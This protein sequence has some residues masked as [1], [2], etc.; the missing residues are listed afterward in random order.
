MPGKRLLITWLRLDPLSLLRVSNWIYAFLT[1]ELFWQ[2]SDDGVVLNVMPKTF[3][4]ANTC[5]SGA[6]W[7]AFQYQ[8]PKRILENFRN[9]VVNTSRYIVTLFVTLWLR[10]T[11]TM[12]FWWIQRS[13]KPHRWKKNCMR[14]R[15]PHSIALCMISLSIAGGDTWMVVA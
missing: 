12:L 11:I 9:F 14:R 10:M 7:K 8:Y 1:L 13:A 15:T 4:R 2:T 5:V 6:S 3:N